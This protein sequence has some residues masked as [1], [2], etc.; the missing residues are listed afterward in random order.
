MSR[1]SGLL[2]PLAQ[3]R[4]VD[5]LTLTDVLLKG[6]GYST[7][8]A[9]VTLIEVLVV[10]A[11]IA[12]LIGL[13]LPAVQKVREAAARAQCLNNLKQLGVGL[14]NHANTLSV[15][16]P[17]GY[18]QPGHSSDPWSALARLLPYLEQANLQNLIDFS[19]S[20]D[21]APLAVTA[22]RVPLFLCPS[23][24]Q[25]HL[26]DAGTHWPLSYAVCAGT[27]FVLDPASGQGGDGAFPPSPA[28]PNGSI[29]PTDV[30]DGLSNTLAMAEVKAFTTYLRDSGNPSGLG[31]PAPA[32]PAAVAAFGGTL[33]PNGGHVEWVDSRTN[34]TGFTTVFTP[35]TVVPLPGGGTSYDVDFTSQRE[36]K[37]ATRPTYAAV[38]ARSYHTGLVQV[39]L[40]DGSA[41]PI[42]NG[43]GLDVWRALGTRAGEEVPGEY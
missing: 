15:F 35:N 34:H 38:T 20:S 16:P 4:V 37:S 43:I 26:D 24:V 39:L 40:L 25:N 23:E 3:E 10:I 27:W 6:R 11:I 18:Y 19:S 41:R 42:Q 7:K 17:S 12:I 1:I 13:L 29:R 8:R 30:S 5:S 28:S 2:P 9:G 22:T 21:A 31:V 36:G 32:S 33:K 14:H